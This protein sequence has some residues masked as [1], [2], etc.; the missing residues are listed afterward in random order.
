MTEA[1]LA[2]S[3]EEIFAKYPKGSPS[4]PSHAKECICSGCY[5][6]WME[7]DAGSKAFKLGAAAEQ[8]R[9]AAPSLPEI[10]ELSVR[11]SEH[12]DA[13][14]TL[15]QV[16]SRWSHLSSFNVAIMKFKEQGI[17]GER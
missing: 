2:L 4:Y 5:A 8:K 12:L 6:S 16:L 9:C 15:L 11:F 7:W 3:R 17:W 10:I 14:V 13:W 1:D